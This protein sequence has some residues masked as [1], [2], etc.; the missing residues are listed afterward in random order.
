[1]GKYPITQAQW[2]FV[3]GLPAINRD[4]DPT[5]SHFKSDNR[6][7]EIVSWYEAVEFCDRLS[8]YTGRTYRLPSEAEWE[9]ACRAGTTT[10]FHF[11]ETLSPEVANYGNK[12]KTT[13][14]GKFPANAFGLCDMH[15]N[16]W[17]WCLDHWHDGYG[18]EAPADGSAW[19]EDEDGSLRVIRGGSWFNNPW[20]CRSAY[21]RASW[22][23]YRNY[24]LGFRV[25]CKVASPIHLGQRPRPQPEPATL[26]H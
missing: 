7:V 9:Y 14:V 11:G 1:M 4:L 2:R 3:A 21:R 22:I 12:G 8:V 24:N 25:V 15:G 17:E 23:G 26:M 6:P 16:V 10:P 13:T 5:P 18:E 20:H 19:V